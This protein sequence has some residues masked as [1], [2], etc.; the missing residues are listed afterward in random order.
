VCWIARL[1][2]ISYR[3]HGTLPPHLC[4]SFYD[5]LHFP[6]DSVILYVVLVTNHLLL[7]CNVS[8]S[9]PERKRS[10]QR[11]AP[12]SG[13]SCRRAARGGLLLAQPRRAPPAFSPVR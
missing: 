10:E 13:R 11:V 12:S 3:I 8:G 2:S 1:H 9:F 4:Q 6:L 5:R 7:R